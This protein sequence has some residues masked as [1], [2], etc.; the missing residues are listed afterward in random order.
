MIIREIGTTVENVC[1]LERA[2]EERRQGTAVLPFR[3]FQMVYAREVLLF[4][5]G[6]REI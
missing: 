4:S 6:A 3:T 1:F 5:E 2:W